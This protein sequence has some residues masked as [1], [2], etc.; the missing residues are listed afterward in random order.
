MFAA[1]A[2]S[3]Q[4]VV[5]FHSSVLFESPE[6]FPKHL[7]LAV[8]SDQISLFEDLL[9]QEYSG[10]H[11]HI[12]DSFSFKLSSLQIDAIQVF[13]RTLERFQRINSDL[14]LKMDCQCLAHGTFFFLFFPLIPRLPT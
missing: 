1:I 7:D 6:P 2:L 10:S 11:Y 13:H 3:V 9:S 8:P 5:Y 12:Q 4:R 14:L